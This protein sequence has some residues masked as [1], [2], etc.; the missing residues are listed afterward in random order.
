VWIKGEL[1]K[2]DKKARMEVLCGSECGD[3]RVLCNRFVLREGIDAPWLAHGIFA[4]V[5]G[6]L[7]SDLQSGG[8]LLRSHRDMASV[9]IQDHGGNWH[10]HGSLN[11]DRHWSLSDTASGLAQL[12]EERFRCGEEREP[13]RCHQCT[14]IVT[15]NKCFCGEEFE[16]KRYSRPVVQ[17]DGE[18]VMVEGQVYKPRKTA[19]PDAAQWLIDKWLKVFWRCRNS[20]KRKM[21]FKAALGLFAKE[22][23]GTWPSP[24]WPMMPMNSVD[25]LRHVCDVEIHRLRP[26]PKY[27]P[28]E[29]R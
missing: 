19:A 14:R 17:S 11:A 25:Y 21:T 26:N 6:S 10:K 15:G 28:K 5:F 20:K 12:R 4:T 13:R 24:S 23:Y 27:V 29:R 7:Q 22:N 8:R 2:S 18:L 1:Y 16:G 9:T 3:I